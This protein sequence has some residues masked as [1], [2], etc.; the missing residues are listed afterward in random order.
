[1]A[2]TP[3]FR[4]GGGGLVPAAPSPRRILLVSL[5]N[6]GDLVFASALTPP[7]QRAYPDAAIDVWSKRY[8]SDVAALIPHVFDVIAA[9]PFWAVPSHVPKPRVLPFL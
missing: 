1:P 4:G 9:D 5:D 3:G 8:T 6:L 2:P 7:L